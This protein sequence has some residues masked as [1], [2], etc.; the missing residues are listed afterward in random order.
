MTAGF[1]A[2]AHDHEA[3]LEIIRSEQPVAEDSLQGCRDLRR[4][5]PLRQNAQAEQTRFEY[6]FAKAEIVGTDLGDRHAQREPCRNDRPGRCAAD[7]VVLVA[8]AKVRIT[9]CLLAQDVFDLLQERE[10]HHTAQPRRHR[11]PEFAWA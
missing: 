2:L 9:T 7:Q 1:E 8:Q 3:S 5:V 10:R 4:I 11:V 6:L